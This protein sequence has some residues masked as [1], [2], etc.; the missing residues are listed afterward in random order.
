ML[1]MEKRVRKDKEW[2][3]IE[4]WDLRVGDRGGRVE[5]RE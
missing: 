5:G 1:K 4:V 3:G 2:V